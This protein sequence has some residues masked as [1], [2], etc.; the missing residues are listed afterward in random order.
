VNLDDYRTLFA[1]MSLVL[2]L[3]AT[4]PVIDLVMPFSENG[5][6]FSE[7]W[8]LGPTHMAEGYPF[9]VGVG[10]GYSVFV[11]VGNRMGRSEYYTVY[12]KFRNQ[13]QPL[14]DVSG[15]KPSPLSPLYEFRFFVADG[16]TWESLLIF[17]ILDASV[18]GDFMFVGNISINGIVFS[19]D[20]LSMRDSE[21]NGFYYQLFFELWLY[22][23]A[24]QSF[25]YHDRFVGIWLNVTAS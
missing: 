19:V 20:S 21:N 1:S 6:S 11:G 13:T 16:E 4:V 12:V 18:H 17:E 9:N 24:T 7:L 3:I 2:I 25:Q 5:E 14:P 22:D 8:L 23:V 10:E 15:S